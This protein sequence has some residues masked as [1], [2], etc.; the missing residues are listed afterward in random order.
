MGDDFEQYEA[1]KEINDA[2]NRAGKIEESNIVIN[3]AKDKVKGLAEKTAMQAI[4]PIL[5]Y[6]IGGIVFFLF[7]L[8]AVSFIIN[9]GCSIIPGA[10]VF[11]SMCSNVSMTEDDINSIKNSYGISGFANDVC[12]QSGGAYDSYGNDC[13]YG[14]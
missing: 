5:P 3:V 12:S 9:V 7:A 14:Y 10:K 6:V 11:S 4:K 8:L 1:E 13:G 2:K